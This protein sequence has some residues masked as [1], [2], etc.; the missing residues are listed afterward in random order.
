MPRPTCAALASGLHHRLLGHRPEIGFERAHRRRM[1]R[2]GAG[3]R[4]GADRD[5]GGALSLRHPKLFDQFRRWTA[6]VLDPAA[7]LRAKTLEMQQRHVK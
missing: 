7:F 6:D 1:R 2:R 5:A 4:D 3:R